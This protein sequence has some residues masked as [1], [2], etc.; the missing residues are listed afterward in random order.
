M[1]TLPQYCRIISILRILHNIIIK[2]KENQGD[3]SFNHSKQLSNIVYLLLK[4]FTS[5]FGEVKSVRVRD[6]REKPPS[7]SA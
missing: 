7:V 2:M 6:Q 4:H 1:P 5:W 3:N